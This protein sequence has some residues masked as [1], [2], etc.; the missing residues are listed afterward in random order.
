[1]AGTSR[2]EL[3]FL[4]AFLENL[5]MD[6]I[7]WFVKA[8]AALYRDKLVPKRV[9]PVMSMWTSEVSTGVK[10]NF[11]RL[12]YLTKKELVECKG[13]QWR[14]AATNKVNFDD[15][16]DNLTSLRGR[17]QYLYLIVSERAEYI[18]VGVTGLTEVELV[19]RY[20]SH[21]GQISYHIHAQIRNG[22]ECF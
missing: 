1:M 17:T 14:L 16:D 19:K 3:L 9:T 15:L 13:D 6:T 4:N 8:G 5:V 11:F 2:F 18:K 7:D 10:K 21:W 20:T 22:K 12:L